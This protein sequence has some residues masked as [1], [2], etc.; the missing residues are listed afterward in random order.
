M[1]SGWNSRHGFRRMEDFFG[2]YQL[3]EENVVPTLLFIVSHHKCTLKLLLT[4]CLNKKIENILI[5]EMNKTLCM[6]SQ[7][8][9]NLITYKFSF[10]HVFV[11]VEFI[12]LIVIISFNSFACER[13]PDSLGG[14]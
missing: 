6:C 2:P 11:S 3:N 4:G 9:I 5:Y 13:L 14:S 10:S 1:L 8:C 7:K 12:D